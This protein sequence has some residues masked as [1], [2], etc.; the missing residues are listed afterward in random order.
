[1]PDTNVIIIGA[2]PNGLSVA[3]HLSAA[4]V[5]RRIF[6]RTMD[7]WRSHMPA[8]MHLKSEPYASDLCAPDAGY[9]LGDYCR[10]AGEPYHHRVVPVS[11]E[12]FLSYGSWFADQLVPDVE[13]VQV[14][15]V[16]TTRDGFALRT[17]DHDEITAA[18]VIVATGIIPF[19]HLPSQLSGLPSELVSHT[20]AHSDL[21]RFKGRKV[22]VVGAGQSA[23]ETAALLHEHGASPKL[24]VRQHWGVFWL[25]P[26]PL[27]P[28]RLQRLRRPV[29]R[30][31]EGWFCWRY[32]RLGDLFRLLPEAT[33]VD[34]GLKTLGPAG[35]WWL[36]ERV[37]GQVPILLGHEVVGAEVC[38][39]G[40]GV[41]MQGPEGS[42]SEEAD[43]LIAG[44]GFRLDVNRL[45]FLDPSLRL[46]LKVAGGAPVLDHSFESSVPGLY[47]TG[48]LAAPSFGP[49]MRFVSG[50]HFTAPRIARRLRR[51]SGRTGSRVDGQGSVRAAQ[52][53]GG[54]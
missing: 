51:H 41:H 43:H 20:S 21:G 9:L 18:R 31:C 39:G 16:S 5:E 27:D 19:A 47:F 29:V 17:S 49:G 25:D 10:S 40:L 38:S 42:V 32:D 37:E 8:G 36:R 44:T 34:R 24:V 6:G 28:T 3:A 45:T 7:A 15:S 46:S 54:R 11:V 12:G 2:G 1:M 14:V 35:A 52:L 23:L 33:R 22:L 50:T 4:G 30:L 53:S 48:A 13:D 26:N